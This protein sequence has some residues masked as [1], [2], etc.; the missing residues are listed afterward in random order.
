[1]YQLPPPKPKQVNHAEWALWVWT[2]WT[3]LW[4]VYSTNN[5]IPEIERS[6]NEQLQGMVSIPPEALL[7][8]AIGGYAIIGVLSGWFVYKLGH[9]KQWARSS[10]LWSFVLQGLTTLA[11]PYHGLQEHISDIPDL[12]LQAYAVYLLYSRVCSDWF[13]HQNSPKTHSLS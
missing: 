12:G 13:A 3:C 7:N 10:F 1:M 2:L 9:G 8:Y 6:L 5:N 11:P 4:G